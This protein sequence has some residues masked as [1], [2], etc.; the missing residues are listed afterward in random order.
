VLIRSII[1]YLATHKRLVIPQLGAFL[2]KEPGR[3]VVFSELIR[4]DDGVLRALLEAE[5][6]TSI[7]ATG[8]ID[9]LVFEVRHGI[10][11]RGEYLLEGLGRFRAGANATL[12]FMYEPA[13]IVAVAP[14]VV[15]E[16][17]VRSVVEQPAEVSEEMSEEESTFEERDVEI[18]IGNEPLHA[19]ASA[20]A[21]AEAEEELHLSVSAKMNP[22]ACVKGLKYGKPHKNTNAFTYVDKPRRSGGDRFIWFA[23]VAILLALGAIAFGFYHEWSEGG[24]PLEKPVVEVQPTDSLTNDMLQ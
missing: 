16:E 1:A 12:M 24:F 15:A 8:E 6:L 22:A 18:V 17:P 21:S 14:T 4:R 10:K 5:G 9:R 7:A 2:V 3:E 23:V 11:E 19:E 20:E 13:P